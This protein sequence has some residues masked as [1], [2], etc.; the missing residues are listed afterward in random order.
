M[1]EL[2]LDA[3]DGIDMHIAIKIVIFLAMLAAFYLVS[4]FYVRKPFFA[5]YCLTL[6]L[7]HIPLEFVQDR[8]EVA[9]VVKSVAVY[10]VFLLP[11]LWRISC[12]FSIDIVP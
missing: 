6:I 11:S 10:T 8:F 2:Q 1:I 5:T 12:M 4:E 3:T 9:V 7:V